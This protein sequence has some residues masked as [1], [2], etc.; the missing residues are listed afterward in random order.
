M[1]TPIDGRKNEHVSRMPVFKER[2]KRS[3]L[4]AAFAL[5]GVAIALG[6]FALMWRAAAMA[7]RRVREIDGQRKGAEGEIP[8]ILSHDGG[9]IDR[10]LRGERGR[11][12]ICSCDEHGCCRCY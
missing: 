7:E 1:S 6:L 5:L 4:V 10:T 11:D 9:T 2:Q 8:C 12:Q 3:K